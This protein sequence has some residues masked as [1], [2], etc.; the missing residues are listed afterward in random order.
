[1]PV[2]RINAIAVPE[3]GGEELVE[4]FRNRLGAVD[5]QPGF[6]GFRLLQPTSE[7]E[8]RWFVVTYWESAEDFDAWVSSVDFKQ[9]HAQ[10][11]RQPVGTGSALLEFDVVLESKPTS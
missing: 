6:Q 7:V 1:M 11:G 9:G 4:R 10:S 3:G 5:D 2:V 8:T